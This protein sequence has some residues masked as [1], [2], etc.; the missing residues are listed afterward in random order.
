MGYFKGNSQAIY[1]LSN[2]HPEIINS[3]D[4]QKS[5]LGGVVNAGLETESNLYCSKL[6]VIEH[7]ESHSSYII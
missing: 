4:L 6:T 2:V 1:W 5:K 7:P 3:C